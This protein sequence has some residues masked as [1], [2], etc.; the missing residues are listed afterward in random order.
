MEIRDICIRE[1]ASLWD[2]TL[3]FHNPH[4]VYVDLS[5]KLFRIKADLLEQMGLAAIG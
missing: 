5:D 2:E 1:K 4:Q 3:R